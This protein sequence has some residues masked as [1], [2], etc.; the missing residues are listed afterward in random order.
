MWRSGLGRLPGIGECAE[1]GRPGEAP[2]GRQAN[3]QP[4]KMP[5]VAIVSQSPTAQCALAMPARAR[6]IL[7]VC[8]LGAA[9]VSR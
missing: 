2:V 6:R 4:E 9:G 3:R 5:I 7:A 8:R 1:A